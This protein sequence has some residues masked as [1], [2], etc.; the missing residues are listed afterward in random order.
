M[1]LDST[2]IMGGSTDRS[3]DEWRR[4]R[5][6]K[7]RKTMHTPVIS[8]RRSTTKGGPL[9]HDNTESLVERIQNLVVLSLRV[10]VCQLHAGF[11]VFAVR[12]EVQDR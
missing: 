1:S 12:R 4:M 9:S 10:A 6:S 2:M 8:R 11:I 3:W 5:T 7:W